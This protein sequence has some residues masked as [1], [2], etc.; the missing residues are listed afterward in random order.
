MSE[1]KGNVLYDKLTPQ[2]KQLVDAILQN[3]ESGAGLWKQGWQTT[4]A[5]I[6][7]ITGKRYNG[8]NRL[9]LTAAMM[10]KG[11]T[12]NRWLT[13]KQMEEKGWSFKR[14]SE[15][16][17][18]GKGAGV[19]IE[20]F[21]LR[22][23]ETK[24]P[25][26][27]HIL[28]GMMSD[29]KDA[30]IDENV[31]P[32]RKYYRV[33]NGDI[34]DGIP[35]REK[36]ELDPSGYSERAESILQ[37][38]SDTEAKIIYG[39]DEAFYRR[40]SDEIHLP[41]KEKFYDLP[42]F[43]ATALHEVGHSTGHK[44]RLNRNMEGMFGSEEYAK[45]ELCAE[46]ASMFIEQDLEISVAEKHI[47]NNSA[48]IQHWKEKIKEDPN[49]LFKA[50]AD[51]EKI[52]KYVM[53]KEK[54]IAN[55]EDQNEEIVEEKSKIFIPPSEVAAQ[56]A[57]TVA[58]TGT[59]VAVENSGRGIESLTNMDDRDIVERA[60]KTKQGEKLLALFNGESVLGD[61]Q[62]DERSLMARLAMMTGDNETQLLRIFRASGQ[63]RADKPDLYYEN[64]A[65]KEMK[66]VAG[67]KTSLP[68][69]T[70]GNANGGRFA[71]AK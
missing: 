41:V 64:M 43:Y 21:E 62:K 57:A 71:N 65:K 59:V 29:E 60:S 39:G 38:W 55:A 67:L 49:V 44:T 16:N 23:K 68:V 18:L 36:R 45:E 19:A 31:Y 20:Y 47:Q 46:I 48:Y 35:E 17:N 24:K 52:T 58:V 28:D 40:D 50:I 53:A 42:E 33:F 12:D 7:A 13:Y 2:R 70:G 14:D 56:V 15:G 37:L 11:Y 4:G 9:F 26:D 27:R 51:A 63:Y 34:I 1:S 3:L 32:I 6:S 66:F 8:V 30:Y 25:F 69:A 61:E 5:P 54:V 22:D 10:Q